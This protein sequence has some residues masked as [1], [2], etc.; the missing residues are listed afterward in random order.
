VP[1]ERD[2]AGAAGRRDGMPEERQENPFL[3]RVGRATARWVIRRSPCGKKRR[4][5]SEFTFSAVAQAKDT[6]F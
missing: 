2:A 4:H 5:G 6:A 3:S 1:V